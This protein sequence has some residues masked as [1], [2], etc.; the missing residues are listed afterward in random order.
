ME[1]SA[2]ITGIEYKINLSKGLKKYQFE[3]FDIN[4]A[5]SCSLLE[6]KSNIFSVSKWVSPK[7]TRSYPYERVYNSLAATKRITVI[8]IVKDEGLEGDRDFL[9]WDTI[10][11][12]S[13]LDVYVILSYYND[14]EIN[15][16]RKNKITK[17][18]HDNDYIL[19]KINEIENYHSSSLHWNLKEVS[20][21]L[22]ELI[23]KVKESYIIL[24]KKLG[25]CF[26]DSEGLDNFKFKILQNAET[27]MNFSRTKAQK[28]QLREVNTIQ[29]KELLLTFTKAS[30]T[31]SNYLGGKY[32]FTVDEALIEGNCIS[33]IE[34]KHSVSNQIPS[35]SDIKDGLLKM[36]LFTNLNDVIIGNKVYDCKSILQLTS[37]K[38]SG[39]ITSESSLSDLVDFFKI[40]KLSTK[41]INLIEKLFKEANQ[42]GFFV[43]IRNS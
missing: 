23:D 4:K 31:I 13:L 42:N 14:A 15:P 16:S 21:K 12:M 43:I 40:N 41:N 27:F 7:R 17:Q 1:I 3:K 6:D 20:Q 5:Q 36:I 28:A 37:L 11:L 24:E 32:F 35:I 10:S 22:P 39:I 33:L 8:P 19:K 25:V 18:K 30:L 9:Q 34:S 29:S 38:I 26:H 2:K